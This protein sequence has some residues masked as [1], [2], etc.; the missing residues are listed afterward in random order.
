MVKHRQ[1]RY[2]EPDIKNPL[3][4]KLLERGKCNKNIR[5]I[6]VLFN[7]FAYVAKTDVCTLLSLLSCQSFELIFESDCVH[8]KLVGCM[9]KLGNIVL[10]LINL[11]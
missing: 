9:L 10:N 5:Q 1:L 7:H 11:F 6:H 2:S 8:I 3:E 4:Y